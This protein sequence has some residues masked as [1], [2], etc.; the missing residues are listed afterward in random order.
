MPTEEDEVQNFETYDGPLNAL[1][2]ERKL[3]PNTLQIMRGCP[4]PKK[5]PRPELIN[6]NSQVFGGKLIFK[7][8]PKQKSIIVSW[9]LLYDRPG[10]GKT[11]KC[12]AIAEAALA[13][14]K[15]N[16]DKTQIMES[17]DIVAMLNAI[18]PGM[19]CVICILNDAHKLHS[20]TA[21][22]TARG[23]EKEDFVFRARHIFASKTG[24]NSGVLIIIA[25]TQIRKSLD[26]WLRE[27]GLIVGCTGIATDEN[28]IEWQSKKFRSW[29]IEFI[30]DITRRVDELQEEEAKSYLSVW[31]PTRERSD[32]GFRL[33]D[34]SD[35]TRTP[36]GYLLIPPPVVRCTKCGF[37]ERHFYSE[38]T[39]CG[40]EVFTV[41]KEQKRTDGTRIFDIIPEL[42]QTERERIEQESDY[43]LL[44]EIASRLKSEGIK[45]SSQSFSSII[46]FRV[47]EW[48]REDMEKSK[49]WKLAG[50]WITRVLKGE[51]K[52]HLE[53][54]QAGTAEEAVK[55]R[56]Q[57]E[58]AGGA[59]PRAEL[60][61]GER[62]EYDLAKEVR[63][64]AKYRGI[65]EKIAE[66]WIMF[67]LD[68]RNQDE[69]ASKF[70]TTQGYVSEWVGRSSEISG[71]IRLDMGLKYEE[72]VNAH[73]RAG[74]QVPGLFIRNDIKKVHE[75]AGSVS[76]KP[77]QLVEYQNG[78]VDVISLKCYREPETITITLD[79]DRSQIRPEMEAFLK[80]KGEKPDNVV[81]LILLIRN[82]AHE[83]FES[84]YTFFNKRDVPT[85]TAFSAKKL[86]AGEIPHV[87]W[88]KPTNTA[89]L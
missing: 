84:F 29:G 38:C 61:I 31:L 23:K 9:M 54:A 42:G 68:R 74:Y 27:Q 65:Q 55:S 28:E 71:L 39:K 22:L 8:I 37:E 72:W 50:N 43:E 19:E 58:G 24:R 45:F 32:S 67:N 83:G 73:L 40:S 5:F 18:R 15:Y 77:D 59:E 12:E 46:A 17:V 11:T 30:A 64:F 13:T 70:G 10:Y 3:Y 6:L 82:V 34:F 79:T 66:A 14:G 76:S 56:M 44:E 41:F 87:I 25:N 86:K 2:V 48:F 80:Y 26:P 20:S 57:S 21:M 63:G 52:A 49:R 47:S 4:K 7:D 51:A 33:K 62:F 53:S 16:L 75:S 89:T 1:P 78:D 60:F 88:T 81:R 36:I 69:I 85:H 35:P